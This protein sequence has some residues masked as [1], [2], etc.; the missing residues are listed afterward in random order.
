[1]NSYHQ[2]TKKVLDFIYLDGYGHSAKTA[3]SKCFEFLEE[4]L[5]QS[6]LQYSPENAET[7][8]K[9]I[10]GL[11]SK[12]YVQ[13]FH[14]ALVKLKDVFL[15]GEIGILNQ[16]KRWTS[17]SRLTDS[18]KIELESYL[19]ILKEITEGRIH[20]LRLLC[21]RFLIYL[22]DR[23]VTQISEISFKRLTSFYE[24]DI[25]S[26]NYGKGQT[27]AAVTGLMLYLFSK[28][29]V[30]YSYTIIQDFELDNKTNP[31]FFM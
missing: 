19:S 16:P 1:M 2:N 15:T 5:I 12:Q 10:T 28:Q 18:L 26:S 22:Q 23:G 9:S 14:S 11:Y 29:K 20:N 25:H 31:D 8:L 6:G 13:C 4:Y 21:S 7:W 27:N 24:D 17:Y 30:P 3:Y